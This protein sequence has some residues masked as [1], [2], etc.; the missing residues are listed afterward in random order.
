MN[1]VPIFFT[2]D[3]KR[4]M[5]FYMRILDFTP[6]NEGADPEWPVVALRNG[7]A[8]LL[9]TS[10]KGDQKPAI[11]TNVVVDKVDE[12]FQRY[13]KRGL[14][15]SKKLESPVHQSPIDQTWGTREFYVTDP[16]GNTLRF[17]QV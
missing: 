5:D 10:V 1:M 2:E 17:V 12:Y 13:I 9:L 14:D 8:W 7:D 15:T 6:G 16:D 3:M 11:N 4:A